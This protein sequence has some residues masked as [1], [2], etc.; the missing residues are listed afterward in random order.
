MTLPLKTAPEDVQRLVEFLKNRATGATLA[1]AKS[2]LGSK[3]LDGRK[4]N[5][6]ETWGFVS[7]EGGRIA[8]TSRGWTLARAEQGHVR[9]AYREPLLGITAYKAALEWVYHQ[10]L[11]ELTVTDV[12]AFWHEHHRDVLVSERET[13]LRDTAVCFFRLCEA[14]EL[15]RLIV[16]RKGQA[17]RFEF[18]WE[19]LGQLIAGS[20]FTPVS[21][22]E[23]EMVTAQAPAAPARAAA[24]AGIAVRLNH[25]EPVMTRRI[26]ISH[27]RNVEVLAQIKTML[28]LAGLQYEV[29]E[30]EETAAIPVPDKI[31]S[32]MRRCSAAVI[33]VTAD[34]TEARD[35]GG[36]GINQNVLIEI[37]AAFVLYEKR[38]VL[39]WDRRVSIPSN[40]QGLYRCEY[41]GETLSWEDGM[42]VM[43]ALSNLR[44]SSPGRSSPE[45][46]GP[47][48]PDNPAGQHQ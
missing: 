31:L 36:F 3:I 32:A 47:G 12:G 1:E 28:D 18:S 46:G 30:E 8:L 33:C 26:F 40:L 15:G 9:E 21:A 41:S 20:A 34:E 44:D 45:T 42:K 23:E 13:T 6:Y 37:G 27:S 10:G 25:E 14:A 5:A 35:D 29:A 11:R 43:K 7:E 4:L 38:V 39:L 19:A 2:I 48:S 17:T 22:T 24:A 16:G